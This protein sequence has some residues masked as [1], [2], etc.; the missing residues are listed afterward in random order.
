[1]RLLLP[2]VLLL[3]P[4]MVSAQPLPC[5]DDPAFAR[6]DFWVG[7]WDVDVGGRIVG[8][9]RIEKALGGCAVLEFWTDV[10]GGEGRSLF[11]YIPALEQWRQVWVT[12]SARTPGGVKEKRLIETFADGAVR[13]QGEIPVAGGGS[14]LDRTTLTP[15]TDGSVRQHIEI[16]R[17][18]G[19]TWTTTFDA[20]YRRR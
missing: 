9:N 20:A 8:H 2:L 16:S 6:L 19:K 7:E 17:D 11:Y 5:A 13:F 18:G 4:S 15:R 14:Y 12:P 10:Q 3:A 1:M